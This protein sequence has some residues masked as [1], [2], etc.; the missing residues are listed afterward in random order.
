VDCAR[1]RVLKSDGSQINLGC[2]HRFAGVAPV[3]GV[4]IFRIVGISRISSREKTT[5][6]ISSFACWAGS[7]KLFGA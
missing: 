4:W 2:G 7:S 6:S 1:R 5:F 3:V